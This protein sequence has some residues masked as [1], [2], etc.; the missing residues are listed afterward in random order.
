MVERA[1]LSPP[2]LPGYEFIR[3]LGSGGFSDVFLYEQQLPKRKVAVKVLT[4]ILTDDSRVQ[5]VAEANRMASLSTHPF[6]V[7]IHHAGVTEDGR[8][9][10]VME[11]CSGPSLAARYKAKPYAIDEALKVGVRLAG[12]VATAHSIG[13]LHRD[14]K[15]ANVLTN[16]YGSPALTDFGIS[17]AL[18]ETVAEP[19][20]DLGS[21]SGTG[22]V[23]LS[24]PWSPPELFD[25]EPRPDVRTD[26]YSL[27]ATVY[28]LIAGFVPFARPDG[29]S[30]QAG[31]IA[32][33]ARGDITSMKRADVPASLISVLLKGMSV[34]PGD[35]FS[36]IIELA[37]ALQRVELE[38]GYQAT[39]LELPQIEE[40][41]SAEPDDSVE[42]T[43]LRPSTT[44]MVPTAVSGPSATAEA[45]QLSTVIIGQEP[46]SSSTTTATQAEPVVNP[47][48]LPGR[49]RRASKK[50]LLVGAGVL[51]FLVAAG[52][53]GFNVVASQYSPERK[54]ETFLQFLVDGDAA[55]AA[56]AISELPEGSTN[57]LN[58]AAYEQAAD[59]ISEFEVISTGIEG[60]TAAVQVRT[61]QGGS[62]TESEIILDLVGQAGLFPVWEVSPESLSRIVL[63]FPRP[64]DLSLTVGDIRV[65]GTAGVNEAEL[66]AFPG[67]YVL[68]ARE[69]SPYLDVKPQSARLGFSGVTN[70][71]LLVEMSDEGRAAAD[72]AVAAHINACLAQPTFSPAGCWWGAG[73]DEDS[74][75]IR[76][77][78]L[79]PPVLSYTSWEGDLGF[80]VLTDTLGAVQLDWSFPS[81]FG[82]LDSSV[83][84][85]D[86][87]ENGYISELGTDGV[88]VFSPLL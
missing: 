59:T 24:I 39:Q 62:A 28:T 69:A 15:P 77:T 60:D 73:D 21:N 9:Y 48:V 54:A 2:E 67:T 75:N 20:V 57:L 46:A 32:R 66:L 7:T 44:P 53:V 18:D 16:D 27:A 25:D 30:T 83:T 41:E 64:A 52:V 78:L 17:V 82:P 4:E 36:S 10:L 80:L 43:Q 76:W 58:Q 11:Y 47:K 63:S 88:A 26:V 81:E 5:F 70:I 74:T 68:G 29:E 8:P 19:L 22:S 79:Q 86:Y 31:M 85:D 1:P 23:G 56:K 84:Y 38:L 61:V 45:A 34:A 12:A 13:I 35:R 14:I 3:L 72:S 42:E 6:I 40:L 50:R 51:L 71:N 65:A 33:I 49:E 55:A 87:R 37:R